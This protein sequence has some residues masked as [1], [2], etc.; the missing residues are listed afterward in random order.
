MTHSTTSAGDWFDARLEGRRLPEHENTDDAY[1]E[2][3]H[4]RMPAN[5]EPAFWICD[6]CIERHAEY[7]KRDA[8]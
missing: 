1:C 2:F 3:C 6:D 4:G 5:P 8:T 7:G